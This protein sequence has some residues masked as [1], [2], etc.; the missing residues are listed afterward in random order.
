MAVT[1]GDFEKGEDDGSAA[2]L[3]I[4]AAAARAWRGLVEKRAPG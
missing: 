1:A 2:S 4:V 3:A